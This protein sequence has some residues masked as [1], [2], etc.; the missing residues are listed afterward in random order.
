VHGVRS[1]YLQIRGDQHIY[2]LSAHARRVLHKRKKELT[3]NELLVDL[4]ILISIAILQTASKPRSQIFQTL[5]ALLKIQ[6]K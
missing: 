4:T 3:R 1:P 6:E 5:D 2:F